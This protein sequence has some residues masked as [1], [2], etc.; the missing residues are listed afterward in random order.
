MALSCTTAD[1]SPTSSPELFKH[2]KSLFPFSISS[3]PKPR[4]LQPVNCRKNCYGYISTLHVANEH[5]K[6]PSF[7]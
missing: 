1:P 6:L 2:T 4:F 7:Y 3:E 5:K